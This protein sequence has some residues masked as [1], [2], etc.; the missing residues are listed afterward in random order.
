VVVR[1]GTVVREFRDQE[2]VC[3]EYC[4][5]KHV[6]DYQDLG[7]GTIDFKTLSV[8]VGT[9]LE[10]GDQV[11]VEVYRSAHDAMVDGGF[12]LVFNEARSTWFNGYLVS[13][14]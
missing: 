6:T 1:N 2:L 7:W 8:S 13:R 5:N 9:L 3:D 12:T 14:L 4:A 10:K 11:W